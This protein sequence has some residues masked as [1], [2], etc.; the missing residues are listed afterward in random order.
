MFED[1]YGPCSQINVGDQLQLNTEWRGITAITQN[2]NDAARLDFTLDD[3]DTTVIT[4]HSAKRVAY[5][6]WVE[7]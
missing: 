3:P 7:A 4:W 1:R 5:R 2:A 6:T